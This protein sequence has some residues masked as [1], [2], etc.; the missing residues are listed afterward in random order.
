MN[1]M[2]H[3]GIGVLL[4]L[5]ATACG[6]ETGEVANA[7][8]PTLD[9]TTWTDMTELF[10]EYPPLVAGRTAL[11]AVHLTR[12]SDFSAMT[13]GRPIL[14]FTPQAG[15]AP[16]RLLGNPPSRPGVFRV[17]APVP[18]AGSYR[19]ALVVD[20]PGWSDRHDLGTITVF[21]DE[22]AA[23][24]DVERSAAADPAAITYLKEP[25]WTNGFATAL[26]QEADMRR[27]IRVPA[28]IAPLTGGAAIVGAPADGRFMAGTLL[29]IGA[30]VAAGQELGRIQPR[31]S[32]AGADR[33]TLA[34]GVA[35]AQATADAAACG[36]R[37]GRTTARRARCSRAPGRGGAA[38]GEDCRGTPHRGRG[39]PCPA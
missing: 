35:E 5:L 4:A 16:M 11:F 3:I 26:V 7:E 39:A 8:P 32:D 34:A 38:G 24:A 14:E 17:E 28:V 9:V 29:S 19:W 37:E 21:A 6:R 1:R 25:Q 33:A 20:A 27:S 12:L 31:L 13:E 36:S 18:A 22:A 2:G 30:R 10:M 15:G 23:V